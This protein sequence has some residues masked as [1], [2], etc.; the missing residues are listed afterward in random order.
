[1]GTCPA[2]AAPPLSF[3]DLSFG[4]VYYAP[5]PVEGPDQPPSGLAAVEQSVLPAAIA[6]ERIWLDSIELIYPRTV[7]DFQPD[8]ASIVVLL[9]VSAP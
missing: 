4:E 7:G 1:M 5:W 8:V 2:A 6:R 9:D 3:Y